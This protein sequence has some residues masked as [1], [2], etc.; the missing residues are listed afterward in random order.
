ML[1]D[2]AQHDLCVGRLAEAHVDAISILADLDG[3]SP[4]AGSRWGGC[5]PLTRQNL[6]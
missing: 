3:T 1:A 6:H 2:L 5:G 4:P